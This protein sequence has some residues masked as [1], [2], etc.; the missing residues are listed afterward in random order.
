VV[1]FAITRR[2]EGDAGAVA[3]GAEEWGAELAGGDGE[4]GEE[5]YSTYLHVG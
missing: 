4:P 1:L 2:A 5:Q 3:G